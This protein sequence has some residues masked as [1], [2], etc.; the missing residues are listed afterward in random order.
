V[1]GRP[2]LEVNRVTF[3]YGASPVVSDVSLALWPGRFVGLLGPNGSGKSTLLRLAAGLLRPQQGTI[4]LDGRP[5][6]SL[7][8]G[9]I[10]R[11]VAVVPQHP[12]LPE[13]LTGWDVALAGRTPHLGVLRG[14]SPL[15][16]AIVRRALAL[17]DAAHLADRRVGEISGGERQRLLLA[18]ALAQEPTVLL[19]DEPTAHLDLPHQLTMLDLSLRFARDADLAILGVFHDLN[20]AAAYCDELSL[21]REGQIVVHGPPASVVSEGWIATVYGLDI[22]VVPHPESGRPVVLLPPA[23]PCSDTDDAFARSDLRQ[24]EQTP[25]ATGRVESE[26][27][28]AR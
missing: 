5:L 24:V 28:W 12:L 7:S 18:R 25:C 4:R 22:T 26:E 8:R 14:T 9:E 1:S 10:A 11:Q 2:R 27:A 17:V 19:L 13:A 21:M 15:D 6:G 16:D 20:L 3:G 23:R